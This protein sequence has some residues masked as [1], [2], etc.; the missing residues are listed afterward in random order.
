[1]YSRT[2]LSGVAIAAAIACGQVTAQGV[3]SSCAPVATARTF[4]DAEMLSRFPDQAAFDRH[5]AGALE[6]GRKAVRASQ[7]RLDSLLKERRD[8]DDTFDPSS[9]IPARVQQ[10]IDARNTSIAAQE[11][12]LR[13]QQCHLERQT[14]IYDRAAAWLERLWPARAS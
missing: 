2:N 10:S 6:P 9:P 12:L 7:Q 11:A 4:S 13:E 14:E 8:F 5:R 1:M 3:V